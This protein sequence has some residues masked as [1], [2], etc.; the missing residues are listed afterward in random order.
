MDLGLDGKV[1]L[2]TSGSK[3]IGLACARAFLD[4]GAK[5]GIVSRHKP[6]STGPASCSV[7]SPDTP[8]TSAIRSRRGPPSM[9][10]RA[11]LA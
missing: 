4:E 7:T 1:V 5:V 6:T 10:W 11:N 9:P 2:I 8:L 3:G